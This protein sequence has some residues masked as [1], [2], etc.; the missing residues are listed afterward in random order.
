LAK[1]DE[2]VNTAR[3]TSDDDDLSLD[4]AFLDELDTE[5][6]KDDPEAEEL[7]EMTDAELLVLELGDDPQ[8]EEELGVKLAENQDDE[9]DISLDDLETLELPEE[10]LPAYDLLEDDLSEDDLP[11]FDLLEEDPLEEDLPIVAPGAPR[12]IDESDLGD[13]DEFDFLSDTD[14]AAT[15]LDLAQAYVEMGDID[16]AR[17]ILMEV[18][19]EGTAEQKAEA[20][21]LLKNLS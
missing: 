9:D 16:G 1:A 12:S 20:K 14:E 21:E 19:L 7:P 8:A 4:E 10:D 17:D 2:P 11:E 5:L 15:K 6:D 13:D 18:E 3:K